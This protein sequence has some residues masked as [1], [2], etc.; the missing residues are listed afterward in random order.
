[1]YKAS[2]MSRLSKAGSAKCVGVKEP[3]SLTRGAHTHFSA[4][5]QALYIHIVHDGCDVLVSGRFHRSRDSM[6]RDFP[7]ATEEAGGHWAETIRLVRRTRD[8]RE[9]RCED[10]IESGPG[11]LAALF[12]RMGFLALPKLFQYCLVQP[13]SV[14]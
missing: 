7:D 10:L 6:F 2:V 4:F 3:A 9:L 11:T 12:D 1:M 14:C 13:T 8:Y 5:P